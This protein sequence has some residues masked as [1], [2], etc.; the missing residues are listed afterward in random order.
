MRLA[1]H[2]YPNV[3]DEARGGRMGPMASIGSMSVQTIEPRKPSRGALPQ[4]GV[5]VGLAVGLSVLAV[6]TI[7]APIRLETRSGRRQ[8]LGGGTPSA[9]D[10]GLARSVSIEVRWPGGEIQKWSN[11]ETDRGHLLIEGLSA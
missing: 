11:V 4:V 6:A 2:C 7:L 1:S 8:R 9:T 3:D 10:S 5:V